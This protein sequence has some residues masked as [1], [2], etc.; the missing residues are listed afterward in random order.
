M[1]GRYPTLFAKDDAR[2]DVGDPYADEHVRDYERRR[3]KEIGAPDSV[4]LEAPFPFFGLVI[5]AADYDV[6]KAIALYEDF[7]FDLVLGAAEIKAYHAPRKCVLC[8]KF[9]VRYEDCPKPDA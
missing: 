6:A 7:D 9:H 5:S 3:N 8:E 4:H 2:A 1:E